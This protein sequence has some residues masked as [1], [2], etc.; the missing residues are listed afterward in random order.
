MDTDKNL[1]KTSSKY[2]EI[3]D[4]IQAE[5]KT[6]ENYESEY[7][8]LGSLDR[9]NLKILEM[10]AEQNEL[11]KKQNELLEKQDKKLK[12][13]ESSSFLTCLHR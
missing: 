6:L 13:I 11:L 7:M 10:L 12:S 3:I 2:G 1:E 4:W 8:F 9:S 5:E